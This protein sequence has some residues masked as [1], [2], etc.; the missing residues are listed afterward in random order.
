MFAQVFGLLIEVTIG[1]Y[2]LAFMLRFIFQLVRADFYNPISQLLVKATDPVLRPA[3]RFIPSA[4]GVDTS[5][6]VVIYAIQLLK[7]ALLRSIGAA[8]TS[9]VGSIFIQTLTELAATTLN[10]Y[11]F[12]FFIQVIVSWINP[13]AYHPG[14][15]LI[16]QVTSPVLAPIRRHLPATGGLDF[17]VMG[18][19]IGIMLAKILVVGTL[20]ALAKA[21]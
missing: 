3:R 21:F 13:G 7:L 4:G 15:V 11:L 1:L 6:V 17:S 16:N 2:L 8:G 19:M 20:D 10:I 14:L 12:A 18:A 9:Q 5:S